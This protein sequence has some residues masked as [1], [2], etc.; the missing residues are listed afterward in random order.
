MSGCS[1]LQENISHPKIVVIVIIIKLH[2]FQPHSP[3]QMPG[4][5]L[6]DWLLEQVKF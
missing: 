5:Q 6:M 4:H 1:V 2:L 3:D